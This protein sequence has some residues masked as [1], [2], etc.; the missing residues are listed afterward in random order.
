MQQSTLFN[1]QFV[2]H[3][4][5]THLIQFFNSGAQINFVRNTDSNFLRLFAYALKEINLQ[6]F[7][8]NYKPKK[9]FLQSTKTASSDS[10]KYLAVVN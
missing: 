2:S 3:V 1:F 7:K 6:S 5:Q 10:V 9:Q 8:L 4:P